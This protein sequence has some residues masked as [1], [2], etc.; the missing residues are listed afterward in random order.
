MRPIQKPEVMVSVV[1][2]KIDA[3]GRLTD[4]K[5]REALRDLLEALAAWVEQLRSTR[6]RI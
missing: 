2:S 4:E 6:P 1:Q 3:A 5:T